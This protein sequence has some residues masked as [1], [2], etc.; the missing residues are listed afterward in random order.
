[1]PHLKDVGVLPTELVA[2]PVPTFP[3][4]KSDFFYWMLQ[5]VDVYGDDEGTEQDRTRALFYEIE[6]MLQEESLLTGL[7]PSDR[8][9]LFTRI[10]QIVYNEL[11]RE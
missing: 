5:P 1:M 9:T 4:Q 10:S 11:R 3:K 6:S 8:R 2:V 7:S